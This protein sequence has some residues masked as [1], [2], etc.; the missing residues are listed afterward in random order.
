MTKHYCDCGCIPSHGT[1][2]E[3]ERNRQATGIYMK[4]LT[5][6]GIDESIAR[7]DRLALEHHGHLTP[8]HGCPRC[9][10]DGRFVRDSAD[11]EWY[12]PTATV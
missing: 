6:R 4:N 10:G 2:E 3:C 12:V 9:P 5:S 1:R 8:H 7:G 11:G